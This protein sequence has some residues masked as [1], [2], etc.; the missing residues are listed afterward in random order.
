MAVMDGEPFPDLDA[1]S[2]VQLQADMSAGRLTARAL[3]EM[4][5]ARIA[6]LD[7]DGP[8]LNAILEVNPDARDVASERD[9][10]RRAGQVRGHSMGF[11]S[12]SRTTSTRQIA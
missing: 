12:C 11:R 4:Y 3:V 5:L 2:I 7:R 8:R 10:E 1:A 9:L 6:A